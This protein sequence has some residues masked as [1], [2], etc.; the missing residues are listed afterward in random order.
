MCIRDRSLYQNLQKQPA[1][2]N[3]LRAARVTTD[4]AAVVLAVKSGG[5][6]AVDLVV[7]PAMLSL[8]TLLT[9]SALGKYMG[10]IQ[11]KL[12]E[13]QEKEVRSLMERKLKRPL[14]KIAVHSRDETVSEERLKTMTR[15]LES[16]DV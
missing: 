12:T 4:A 1:T 11:K 3:G 14:L 5:L 6:G 13:Y 8:T 7:A 2:L 10:R 15:K 16:G 9:E